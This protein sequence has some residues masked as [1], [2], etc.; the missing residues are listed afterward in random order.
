MDVTVFSTLAFERPFLE[1]A[2]AGRHQ[3]YLTREALTSLATAVVTG[4]D[5]WDAGQPAPHEL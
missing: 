5:A 1:Q 3:G 2:S 4:L